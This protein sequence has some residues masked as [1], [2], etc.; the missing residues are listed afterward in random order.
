M[1]KMRFKLLSSFFVLKGEAVLDTL[2]SNV[3][4]LIRWKEFTVRRWKKQ[5]A[6]A[7][8]R[9]YNIKLF[10]RRISLP[11][12]DSSADSD[13]VC[14]TIKNF[15]VWLKAEKGKKNIQSLPIIRICNLKFH[16]IKAIDYRLTTLGPILSRPVNHKDMKCAHQ[17]MFL[18]WA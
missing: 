6:A 2:I 15:I 17:I 8:F 11:Q 5:T 9:L 10:F 12:K 16:N 18:S 4:E 7:A 14:E 3:P 1:E 13:R